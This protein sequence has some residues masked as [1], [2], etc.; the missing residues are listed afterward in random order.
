MVANLSY[1][2]QM[3]KLIFMQENIN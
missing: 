3:N 2:G 1:Q